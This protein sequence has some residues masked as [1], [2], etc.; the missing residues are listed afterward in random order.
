M[1]WLGEG[2]V[3]DGWS[4]AA[5]VQRGW[6]ADHAWSKY[7]LAK[8][9]RWSINNRMDSTTNNRCN[10]LSYTNAPMNGQ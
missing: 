3:D 7:R 8:R 10:R 4:E 6:R 2:K 9:F 5:A 1:G